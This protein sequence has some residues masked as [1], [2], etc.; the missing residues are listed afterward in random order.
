[1][2]CYYCDAGARAVC[3]FC[4]A[5]VCRDHTRAARYISGVTYAGERWFVGADTVFTDYVVTDNAIWCG[6]CA[7]RVSRGKT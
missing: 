7:V 5:A 6:R 4:G 3:R 2:Q 1:M